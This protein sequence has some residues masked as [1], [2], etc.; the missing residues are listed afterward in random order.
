MN[1]IISAIEGDPFAKAII[2]SHEAMIIIPPG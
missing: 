2:E 1:D